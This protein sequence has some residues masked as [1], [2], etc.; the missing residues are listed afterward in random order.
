MKLRAEFSLAEFA[1]AI[2]LTVTELGVWLAN[3]SFP[4]G[5]APLVRATLVRAVDNPVIRFTKIPPQGAGPDRMETIAGTVSGVNVQ[6]CDCR[7]V[8]Y[9]KGDVYY[10]QPYVNAP[11]TELRAD[12]EF[13]NETHLGSHYLA[14]LV[15]KSYQP[16]ATILEAPPV[17]GAVL[18]I[19]VVKAKAEERSSA[20]ARAIQFSGY[21]WNVKSSH[22]QKAGP[23]PNIF[24]DGAENVRVDSAG[25]LHLRITRRDGQWQCAEVVLAESYGYGTYTFTL[26]SAPRYLA[27]PLH[28]VL[29]MFTWNDADTEHHHCEID[30]EISAWSKRVNKLG[31]WVIQPYTRP[32]NLLRFNLPAS[33]SATEHTFTWRPDRVECESLALD[34]SKPAAAG[35]T[36]FRHAF[37][38]GIPPATE[39][40]NARIN[41]WLFNGRPP[42]DGKEV[43]V[44]IRKFT[45][46]S[47][48]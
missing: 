39:G 27:P 34:P 18:A 25:R 17:G 45:Y 37:D 41:L 11:Y 12:G 10:V 14:A 8:L 9:A 1:L 24:S 47:L 42:A 4:R 21:N 44:V 33:L 43:E 15:K 32:G 3:G 31:Q 30:A 5:G 46:S 20:P 40:T 28:A 6:T 13:E 22:D 38:R 36:L 19:T 23:G 29:G 2:L 26:D 7:I 35:R 16:S 48:H